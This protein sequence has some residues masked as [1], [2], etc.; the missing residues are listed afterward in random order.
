MGIV[1]RRRALPVSILNRSFK[2]LH[3]AS[4]L[5]RFLP[6]KLNTSESYPLRYPEVNA[7]KLSVFCPCSAYKSVR[8]DPSEAIPLRTLLDLAGPT[9]NFQGA[10]ITLIL[11]FE[12]F[13]SPI[14][15][16]T[17][18]PRFRVD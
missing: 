2:R 8:N 12:L 16:I 1:C 10:V 6:A 7:E 15:A 11:F 3:F 5:F 9:F 18:I 4:G 13:A 17:L 14:P